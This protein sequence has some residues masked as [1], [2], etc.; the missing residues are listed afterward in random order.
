MRYYIN[1][2]MERSEDMNSRT[3]GLKMRE[4]RKAKGLTMTQFAKLIRMTQAQ[5]SRLENGKQGFRSKTLMKVAKA[6]GVEPIYFFL[7]DAPDSAGKVG[8]EDA[9]YGIPPQSKLAVALRDP[10]FRK[11]ADGLARM[12]V[13]DAEVTAGLAG[14]LDAVR[15]LGRV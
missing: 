4:L 3:I 11:L 1:E 7:E 13:R 10:S 8:K 12:H 14:A 9:P 2:W 15:K 5:V 6:L